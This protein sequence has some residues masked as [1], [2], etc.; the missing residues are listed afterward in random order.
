MASTA[1]TFGNGVWGIPADETGIIIETFNVNLKQDKKTIKDRTGNDSS[2][3][4]YNEQITGSMKGRIPKTSPYNTALAT[5][6][7]VMNSLSTGLLKGGATSG[8]TLVDSITLDYSNE[9]YQS[10]SVEFTKYPNILS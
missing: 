9:D 5:S 3:T 2:A 4:F 8:L 1:T 6:L 10:I 7:T